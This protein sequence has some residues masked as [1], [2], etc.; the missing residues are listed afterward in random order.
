MYRILDK[1]TFSENIK[2]AEWVW[3]YGLNS[4]IIHIIIYLK[5]SEFTVTWF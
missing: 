5:L 1:I 4:T 3:F 2:D